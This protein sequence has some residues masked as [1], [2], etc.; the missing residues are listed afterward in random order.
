MVGRKIDPISEEEMGFFFEEN[1]LG[2]NSWFPSSKAPA[3]P[4]G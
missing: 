4:E 3:L 2:R 1:G